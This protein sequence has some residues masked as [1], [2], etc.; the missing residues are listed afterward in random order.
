ML[1][2]TLLIALS[3]SEELVAHQTK[4]PFSSM[5]DATNNHSC[6]RADRFLEEDG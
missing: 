3:Q 2:L 5:Q 1:K 6:F 4:Q